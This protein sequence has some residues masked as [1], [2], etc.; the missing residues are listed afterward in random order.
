MLSKSILEL[1]EWLKDAE[2]LL[3]DVYSQTEPPENLK[4]AFAALWDCCED[5]KTTFE[6]FS[7]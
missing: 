1:C 2:Q 5:Y 7:H 4:K 6:S 3:L